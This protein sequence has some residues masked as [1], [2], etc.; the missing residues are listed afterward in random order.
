VERARIKGRLLRQRDDLDLGKAARDELALE[1]VVVD[2]DDR[3]EADLQL[4]RQRAYVSRLV[5][6]VRLER[7]EIIEAQNHVRKRLEC[8]ARNLR[9]VLAGDRQNDP[10]LLQFLQIALEV[11]IGLAQ[12]R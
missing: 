9:I 11:G 4:R 5:V 12:G 7:A 8:F 6:P 3:I 2:E 1:R 10:S